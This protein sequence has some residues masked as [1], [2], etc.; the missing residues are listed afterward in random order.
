MSFAGYDEIL[1]RAMAVVKEKRPRASNFKKAAFA[2]AV[3][4]LVT[5]VSGG[6]GGP[7]VREY[8]AESKYGG[9]RR[10]FEEA[11]TL[12]LADDGPIFGPITDLHR[13]F[14]EDYDCFDDDPKDI[15]ELEEY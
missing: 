6:Y 12:L 8:V 10:S 1:E 15:E 13:M 11:C 3:S 9:R 5:G 7:S 4:V 14:W 2:N